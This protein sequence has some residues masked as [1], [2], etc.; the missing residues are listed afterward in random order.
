MVSSNDTTQGRKIKKLVSHK[1]IITAFRSMSS[2]SSVKCCVFTAL[3]VR[4]AWF[5]G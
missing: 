2:W 4:S 3:S 5:F 1:D